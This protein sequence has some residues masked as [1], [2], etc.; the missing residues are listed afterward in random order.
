M[1]DTK[2]KKCKPENIRWWGSTEKMQLLMLVA[3]KAKILNYFQKA[4][5]QKRKKEEHR[6][7]K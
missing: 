3:K 5:I 6:Q 1:S 2:E 4:H 7:R